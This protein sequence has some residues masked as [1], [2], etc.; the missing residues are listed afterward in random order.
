MASHRLT[1]AS[2]PPT[3][4]SNYSAYPPDMASGA[5]FDPAM[6]IA[7]VC[8]I[9]AFFSIG[10]F[11]G[12]LKRCIVGETAEE[13]A[14]RLHQRRHRRPSVRPDPNPKRGLTDEVIKAL[15]LVRYKDMMSELEQ[16]SEDLECPVC[17]AP[18]ETDDNLRLLPGCNHVFHFDCIAAWFSSHTTCPLCRASLLPPIIPKHQQLSNDD[19][20]I[21]MPEFTEAEREVEHRDGGQRDLVLVF[22]ADSSTALQ[23]HAEAA[24]TSGGE[25]E[26]WEKVVRVARLFL[27]SSGQSTSFLT[28]FCAAVEFWGHW[29]HMMWLRRNSCEFRKYLSL[30]KDKNSGCRIPEN[31]PILLPNP[32]FNTFL[33]H[34]MGNVLCVYSLL[35]AISVQL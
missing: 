23:S 8:F 29:K 1:S 9:A 20:R 31:K 21:A 32:V 33:W 17:L 5:R 6:A 14:Y 3:N 34:E 2:S 18:F 13:T 25:S 4:G 12:Q 27:Q 35:S 15:P 19:A 24:T 11:A 26:S 22:D 16:S 10:F 28:H 7:V 30:C